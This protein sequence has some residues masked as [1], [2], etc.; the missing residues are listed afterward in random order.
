MEDMLQVNCHQAHSSPESQ[1]ESPLHGQEAN[2]SRGSPRCTERGREYCWKLAQEVP[3]THCPILSERSHA[4]QSAPEKLQGDWTIECICEHGSQVHQ[5][6]RVSYFRSPKS[7]VLTCFIQNFPKVHRERGS[8]NLCNKF[9]TNGGHFQMKNAK[10]IL[11]R[12]WP[13]CVADVRCM[14]W[15]LIMSQS[16]CSIIFVS[17]LRILKKR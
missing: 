14:S 16:L 6:W 11:K 10:A 17:H 12:P 9:L 7:R 15:V 2:L 3:E 5:F 4:D 8:T 1:E 13:P